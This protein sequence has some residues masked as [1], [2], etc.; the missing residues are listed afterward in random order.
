MRH[1]LYFPSW[2]KPE[3]IP[4][5]PV[6]WYGLMYIFAF[7]TAFFVFKKQVKERRF[8][9]TEDNMYSVFLWGIVGLVLG[10]RIFYCLVYDTPGYFVLH[11]WMIFWPFQDGHFT[12]LAGMSY[13]GG[14]IG[15][16]LGFG[17]YSLRKKWDLREVTDL[18]CT[19]IPLGYSWGR[20]GN[21]INGELYGRV[22]A[23]PIGM[24]FPH[25]EKFSARIPQ[26]R[27]IAE[28]TGIPIPS[29]D[30]ML[31]LPRYPSQLM[32]LIFE[33]IVCWAILWAIR[34]YKPF[35]GFQGG[36]YVIIYGIFR[37]FIEYFREP[38]RHLGYRIQFGEQ[39]PISEI[40]WLHPIGSLSTGQILCFGMILVG[41]IWWTCCL[42][43]PNAR[44]VVYVYPEKGEEKKLSQSEKDDAKKN[45]RK[46]RKKL[47]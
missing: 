26:V 39:V 34:K 6:R 7:A 22:T 46:L 38:D 21:F 13:H 45:R 8:P 11:P 30:A 42:A 12:G 14:V 40:A 43:F 35:K 33:G 44:P 31:N 23:S 10:A 9:M 20:L 1:P 32:E 17:L 29:P 24:V 36:A 18:F 28:Q 19:A 25:A 15:G 37:F 2:L 27:E 4:G 16:L 5:L 41:L 3:I 47:K